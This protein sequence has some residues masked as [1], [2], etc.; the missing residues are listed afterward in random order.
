MLPSHPPTALTPREFELVVKEILEVAGAP[1]N[2][3]SVNHLER[4]AG[5]DGEYIIDVVVRF[6]ALGADFLVL[7]EC[8][9]LIRKVERQDVQVL[10][11]KVASVG[12]HKGMIFSNSGFQS[13]A[14]EFATAHGIALVQ[15]ANGTTVWFTRN[16]G[17]T[18][19]PPPDAGIPTYIGWW[20]HGNAMTVLSSEN[21]RYVRQ[22]LGLEE[23][24][25]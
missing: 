11:A 21:G 5:T 20:Y 17:A 9:H 19:P 25:A 6:L 1:L 13:G 16:E 2:S 23:R 15:I 8:K 22:A 4:I 3:F 24:E 14:I 10:L 18:V 7:V 12:A